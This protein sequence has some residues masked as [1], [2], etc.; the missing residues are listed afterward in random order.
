MTILGGSIVSW[1]LRRNARNNPTASFL[2]SNHKRKSYKPP[3]YL[4]AINYLFET[5]VIFLTDQ[6]G[7]WARCICAVISLQMCSIQSKIHLPITDAQ[8]YP[9]VGICGRGRCC[10]VFRG[11]GCPANSWNSSQRRIWAGNDKCVEVPRRIGQILLSSSSTKVPFFDLYLRL[12]HQKNKRGHMSPQLFKIVAAALKNL[13]TFDGKYRRSTVISAR[14]CVT[15]FWKLVTLYSVYR[16]RRVDSNL[17]SA[18]DKLSAIKNYYS[19]AGRP[20]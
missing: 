17:A 18:L 8:R 16:T 6:R 20:R 10:D 5:C 13:F 11:F 12:P 15:F 2:H 3:T 1:H 7:F 19:E 14:T 4:L 9:S